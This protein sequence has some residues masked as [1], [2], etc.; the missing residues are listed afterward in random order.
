MTRW[1]G[2]EARKKVTPASELRAVVAVWRAIGALRRTD[3]PSRHRAAIVRLV[4][5]EQSRRGARRR[6]AS[7]LRGRLG[8]CG[9]PRSPPRRRRLWLALATTSVA[10]MGEA[11][12]IWRTSFLSFKDSDAN[13]RLLINSSFLICRFLFFNKDYLHLRRPK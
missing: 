10:A 6:R 11:T 3:A 8:R 7:R 12:G 2:G 9:F 5:H 1:L 13:V 4:A